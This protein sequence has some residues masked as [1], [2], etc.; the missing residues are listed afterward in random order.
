VT[1]LLVKYWTH[2]ES[3][4]EHTQTTKHDGSDKLI[5]AMPIQMKVLRDRLLAGSKP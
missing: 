3:V 2:E 5:D 4:H 1:S